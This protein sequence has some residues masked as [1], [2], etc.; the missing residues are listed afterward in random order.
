MPIRKPVSLKLLEGQPPSEVNNEEPTPLDEE[1]VMPEWFT[2]SQIRL[3]RHTTQQLA[4]MHMLHAADQET[5][6]N[7]VILADRCRLLANEFNELPYTV[8]G[9]NGSIY[10][11]PKWTVLNQSVSRLRSYAR[12]LGL[13]PASRASLRMSSLTPDN[14]ANANDPATFFRAG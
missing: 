5:I 1:P 13:T 6:I 12:E 8:L 2:V 9:G 7:Y 14:E 3:W 11:H 4:G 10:A